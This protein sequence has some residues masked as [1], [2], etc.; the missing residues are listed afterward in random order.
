[1]QPL[2]RRQA[3]GTLAAG[4]V[5]PKLQLATTAQRASPDELARKL[6]DAPRDRILTV[7]EPLASEGLT[8][9]ELLAAVFQAGILEIRPRPVGFKLHAVLVVESSFQLA[10][11]GSER[12]AWLAALWNLD[13]FK[14]SQARDVREGDWRLGAIPAS[15]ASSSEVAARE[16]R[17]A[18]DAW[19]AERADRAVTAA[20]R[21]MATGEL[22]ELL[23]PYCMRDFTNLGHKPI[24]CSHV[25]RVLARAPGLDALPALRSLVYGLLDGERGGEVDASIEACAAV[26]AGWRAGRREPTRS[27]EL[28][29]TL[30]PATPAEARAAVVAALREGVD[31][32]TVWDG[33]RLVAA[34]QF[35]RRPE[36]LPVHP[37]TVTSAMHFIY[38]SSQVESTRRLA[39]M[40]A[41]SWLPLFR[42]ALRMSP[43]PGVFE[44]WVK[45]SPV[46]PI[47]LESVF[48]SPNRDRTRDFV[49]GLGGAPRFGEAL[50]THL[51][52]RGAREHHQTKY[53]AAVLEDIQTLD[54]RWHGAVLASSLEYLPSGESERTRFAAESSEWVERR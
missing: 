48:R 52:E 40:Q 32:S 37:T 38:R 35:A 31:A 46:V 7:V 2:D 12:E 44:R 47:S 14:H 3:L 41:A 15:E 21:T 5:I 42:S 11:A 27:L 23:W 4:F 17:A 24:F 1:M 29:R 25:A 49:Q 22:F 9:R 10:E 19:D 51:L 20:A 34:D 50:R 43:D 45:P 18:L 8:W 28:A 39:L 6:I 16:L 26:P 33:L 30:R 54:R 13:D 53:A 36:L